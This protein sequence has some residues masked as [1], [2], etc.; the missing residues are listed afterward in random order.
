MTLTKSEYD[1]EVRNHAG[2]TAR[3]MVDYP[4]D[5][6]DVYDAVVDTLDGHD[7]FAATYST[8]HG[9][10]IEHGF[11]DV[12]THRDI[13]TLASADEPRDILRALAFGQFEADVIELTLEVIEP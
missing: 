12:S 6:D 1:R 8:I 7:W 3:A 9:A 4:D 13:S 11:A 10:V 2:I 5:Y